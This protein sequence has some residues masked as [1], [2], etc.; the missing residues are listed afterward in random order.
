VRLEPAPDFVLDLPVS[1][2]GAYQRDLAVG[3]T[4]S[5][6]V[7]LKE[8][9]LRAFLAGTVTDDFLKELSLSETDAL[10]SAAELAE[11]GV[12]VAYD[13]AALSLDVE[14]PLRAFAPRSLSVPG[15]QADGPSEDALVPSRLS[16]GTNVLLRPTLTH[17]GGE[18]GLAPLDG[19]IEG[20]V[21]MGGFRGVDLLYGGTFREGAPDPVVIDDAVLIYD[22]FDRAV[23]FA[24]GTVAVPLTGQFVG[25]PQIVGA[26]VFRDYA[27]IQP[28]LNLT[29]NGVASFALERESLLTILVDGVPVLTDR[30]APG[31]YALSDLP[32]VIG[33]NDVRILAEDE[34]GQRELAEFTPYVDAELL[35]AGRSRFALAA[36]QV[37]ELGGLFPGVGDDLVTILAYERGVNDQL[38]MGARAETFGDAWQA[39]SR[40]VFGTA[41]GLVSLEGAYQED[42]GGGAAAGVARYAWLSDPAQPVSHRFDA[43]V[44]HQQAT[45]GPLVPRLGAGASIELARTAVNLRYTLR[46]GTLNVTA[47]TQFDRRGPEDQVTSTLGLNAFVS[48]M[49]LGL[50]LQHV[51]RDRPAFGASSEEA[52]IFSIGRRLGRLAR[53]RVAY[54]TRGRSTEG[55]FLKIGGPAVGDWD[56]RLLL[57]DDVEGEAV[58]AAIGIV[59]NRAEIEL[60]HRTA[61]ESDR[62]TSATT[63]QVEVGFGVAGGRFAFGRPFDA[64]FAIVEGHPSLE[65]RRIT[66]DQG[67]DQVG[68]RT[69]PLGPALLPIR[70]AYRTQ[71]LGVAVEDLP[72][73]VDMGPAAIEVFP[74]L[75]SGYVYTVGSGATTT[76]MGE[77][78]RPDG[79]PMALAIGAFVRT[80]GDGEPAGFFT[81]KTGRFVAEGLRAGAYEVRMKP[82]DRVVGR[83][84]VEDD[85][86]GLLRLGTVQMEID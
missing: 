8:G 66:L 82:D 49:T 4:R 1:I 44:S 39:D 15:V 48:D 65:D 79:T 52:I 55:Q 85:G 29:P 35:S 32:L 42:G 58:D 38:T 68:A 50:N 36:G 6:E 23:R 74:D 43:Q 84:L 71:R 72:I 7:F 54:D 13:Q 59:T 31:A 56:G 40:V 16:A 62:E 26:G 22:D 9:D 67:A 51:W 46:Y 77:L 18:A 45:F 30:F 5:G 12:T 73:G 80:D 75:R 41:F 37:R 57:A 76:V 47:G 19:R 69:G 34:T 27:G 20:F 60:A 86:E 10:V 61:R 14:L 3:V 17:A 2:A 33:A 78:L 28:F 53:G 21:S 24:V 25:A 83:L 64:G 63:A 81:N 70:N 11:R